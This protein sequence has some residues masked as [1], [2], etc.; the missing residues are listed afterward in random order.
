MKSC[1]RTLSHR[2]SHAQCWWVILRQ[3]TVCMGKYLRYATVIWRINAFK[4][5]LLMLSVV[6]IQ[7]IKFFIRDHQSDEVPRF[8]RLVVS[9]EDTVFDYLAHR[10]D[11]SDVSQR[12]A[13]QKIQPCNSNQ[14]PQQC[15]QILLRIAAVRNIKVRTLHHQV[16]TIEILQISFLTLIMLQ[17]RKKCLST[18]KNFPS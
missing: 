4:R 8:Q 16:S 14:R 2:K 6:E 7:M 12:E 11:Y 15:Q 17:F 5:I 18:L 3:C 10:S 13:Y 1:W 9:N